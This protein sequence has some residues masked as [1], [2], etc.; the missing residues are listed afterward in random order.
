MLAAPL[1]LG[2][3]AVAYVARVACPDSGDFSREPVRGRSVLGHSSKAPS[4]LAELLTL[5]EA[6]NRRGRDPVDERLTGADRVAETKPR[7]LGCCEVR[8]VPASP[9]HTA[10]SGVT[11]GRPS[12]RTVETQNTSASSMH[13]RPSAQPVGVAPGLLKPASSSVTGT[14]AAMSSP[15][16]ENVGLPISSISRPPSI[17]NRRQRGK[18]RDQHR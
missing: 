8:P 13:R 18:H 17:K 4:R 2:R 1:W 11:C 6:E 5:A 7:A 15:F 10:S 3:P 12:G 9:C 14:S 16:V